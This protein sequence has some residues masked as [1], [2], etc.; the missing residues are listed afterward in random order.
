LGRRIDI[1]DPSMCCSSGL[2]GPAADPVLLRVNEAVSRLEK[3]Y[4][5]LTISRHMFGRAVKAFTET[6]VV[7]DLIQEQGLTALPI[8]VLNGREVVAAG[9]YPTYDELKRAL[10]S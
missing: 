1:F 3:E 10:D 9:R 7:M 6:P 8:T 2:C 5:D 4:A